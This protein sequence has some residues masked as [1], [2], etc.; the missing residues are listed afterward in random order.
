M[1]VSLFFGGRVF[2]WKFL[3]LISHTLIRS[4][5][6]ASRRIGGILLVFMGHR[7]LQGGMSLGLC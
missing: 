2:Q 5:K 7:I 6:A 3:I 1:V 4:L